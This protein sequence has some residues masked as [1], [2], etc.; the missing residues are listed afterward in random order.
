[1]RR[2]LGR[3]VIPLLAGLVSGFPLCCIREFYKS[4]EK[5]AV[6]GE[7]VGYVR[8]EKCIAKL[9]RVPVYSEWAGG[10]RW[11]GGPFA[12]I[13]QTRREAIL[14]APREL[15]HSPW[16][17][18]YKTASSDDGKFAVYEFPEEVSPRQRA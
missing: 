12:T 11:G 8:C 6:D 2:F 13:Y 18:R 16:W 5:R 7:H 4:P 3:M 10:W 15:W 17:E 9:R 1:M 14:S